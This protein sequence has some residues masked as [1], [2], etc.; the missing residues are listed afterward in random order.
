MRQRYVCFVQKDFSGYVFCKKIRSEIT[1]NG[2]DIV[3]NPE[4]KIFALVI[5]KTRP[6]QR[7]RCRQHN[8]YKR[9]I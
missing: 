1:F 9:F 6:K 4:R 8:S 3:G 2:I 7:T 5:V